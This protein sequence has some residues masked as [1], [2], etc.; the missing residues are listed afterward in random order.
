[1]DAV[2]L[3]CGTRMRQVISPNRLMVFVMFIFLFSKGL[4]L[5]LWLVVAGLDFDYGALHLHDLEVGGH[6]FFHRDM[7]HACRIRPGFV[8][9]IN[10]LLTPCPVNF[11]P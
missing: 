9:A 2:D 3:P 1:M 5:R 4:K 8:V 10:P 11:W 7:H 6:A